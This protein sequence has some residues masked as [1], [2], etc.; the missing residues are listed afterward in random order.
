MMELSGYVPLKCMTH[1]EMSAA[2]QLHIRS[3]VIFSATF[4]QYN[5][6][7]FSEDLGYRTTGVH[8]GVV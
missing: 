1:Q 3:T 5:H 2:P 6:S 8:S 4:K 7:A